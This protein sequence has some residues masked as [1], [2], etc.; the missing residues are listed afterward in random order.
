MKK[1]L[2]FCL[3]LMLLNAGSLDTFKECKKSTLRIAGGTAHIPI[4]KIVSK[5]INSVNQNIKIAIAGGGSGVGIKKVGEGLVDIGNSGRKPSENEIQKYNLKLF[6]WAIDGI[7]VVV[8]PAN[9]IDNL[10]KKQLQD[11]FSGKITNW[12][13][14]G[15]D[16]KKIVVY[17]RDKASG[18]RKVFW[19]KL[20]DKGE[21]LPS[22]I[23]AKSNGAMRRVIED[24][25]YA[26][27]YMSAGFI[28]EKIKGVSIDGIAPTKDNIKSGKYVFVRGLY[29]L[30]KGEPSGLKKKFIEYLFSPHV[31]NDIVANKGFIPVK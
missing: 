30:T 8:N 22:A 5:E 9:K 27:G 31:Q 15:G 12:K 29:S 24:N 25:P 16:N 13:E 19:K 28:D 3:G 23:F 20:L 21:I 7:A 17:T 26:I 18:T 6:K 14:L 10:T 1:I 11:I 2:L 4:M